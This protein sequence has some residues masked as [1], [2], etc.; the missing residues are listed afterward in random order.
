MVADTPAT[1]GLRP[2]ASTSP[3]V[4]SSQCAKC[5]SGQL[6]KPPATESAA[7]VTNTEVIVR[8]LSLACAAAW[9]RGLPKNTMKIWRPT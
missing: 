2:A 4:C 9:L 3:N 6:S 5:G 8:G 1:T 7:R